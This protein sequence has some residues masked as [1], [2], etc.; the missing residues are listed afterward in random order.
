V[1]ASVTTPASRP[2]TISI[3]NNPRHVVYGALMLELIVIKRRRGWVWQVHDQKGMV[4]AGGRGKT[5]PAAR[6]HAYRALFL[7][8]ATGWKP[9]DLRPSPVKPARVGK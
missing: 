1:P 5:R 2:E 8:I 9:T 7:S 6:Y 3:W 4:I